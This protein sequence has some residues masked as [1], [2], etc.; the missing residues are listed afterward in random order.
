MYQ[1]ME[2]IP[3]AQAQTGKETAGPSMAELANQLAEGDSQTMEFTDFAQRLDDERQA[4]EVAIRLNRVMAVR[5]TP[6]E[7]KVVLENAHA[8]RKGQMS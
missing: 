2:H 3:G 6:E 7:W 5:L 4:Q 1:E 8:I